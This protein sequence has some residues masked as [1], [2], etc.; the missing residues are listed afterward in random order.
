MN[1]SALAEWAAALIAAGALVVARRARTDSRDSATASTASATSSERSA[2]AAESSAEVALLESRRA[3]ERTDVTWTITGTA[4]DRT[5]PEP[6]IVSVR[7]DGTT[8][9]RA[10]MANLFVNGARYATASSTVRPA[11]SFEFDARDGYR[12]GLAAAAAFPES[13]P[14]GDPALVTFR[15]RVAWESPLGT[16]GLFDV[17][18]YFRRESDR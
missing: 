7:N 16:P 6:G 17:P 8:E 12:A 9:A 11:E 4:G 10:V 3:V 15:L 5:G 18:G 14:L 13:A 1:W 2:K